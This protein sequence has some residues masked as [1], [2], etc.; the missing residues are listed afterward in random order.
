VRMGDATKHATQKVLKT[1]VFY[2]YKHFY[3]SIIVHVIYTE[4][5]ITQSVIS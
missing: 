2:C 3:H 1:S 4:K 5:H